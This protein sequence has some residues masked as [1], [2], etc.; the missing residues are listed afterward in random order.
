MNIQTKRNVTQILSGFLA[1]KVP[2]KRKKSKKLHAR[3]EKVKKCFF[4][5]LKLIILS[6][7]AQ[8]AKFGD[9]LNKWQF[10][11]CGFHIIIYSRKSATYLNSRACEKTLIT[12]KQLKNICRRC[13]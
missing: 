5:S 7:F 13:F 9:E 3:C 2:Q 12:D 6:T 1:D 10:I 4:Q 8:I 11:F